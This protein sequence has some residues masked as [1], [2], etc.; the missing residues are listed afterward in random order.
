MLPSCIEGKG[1]GVRV[2]SKCRFKPHQFD[3]HDF[4][5]LH[6]SPACAVRQLPETHDCLCAPAA[7]AAAAAHPFPANLTANLTVNQL[8]VQI[9][10][11][12]DLAQTSAYV[13]VPADSSIYV[14]FTSSLDNGALR[15]RPRVVPYTVIAD[16]VADVRR[17]KIAAFVTGRINAMYFTQVR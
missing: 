1:E 15:L 9:D 7:A 2:S 14:Y 17:G 4:S 11:L 6:S 16:A 12:A 10:S 8:A 5:C 3:W 13:G